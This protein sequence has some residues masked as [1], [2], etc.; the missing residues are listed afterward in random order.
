MS[1]ND[2]GEEPMPGP[3]RHRGTALYAISATC[4]AVGALLWV[5]GRTSAPPR[6]YADYL[7]ADSYTPSAWRVWSPAVPEDR[8]G[9]YLIAAGLVLAAAARL[10]SARR[11]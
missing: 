5:R 8:L 1:S 9:L 11:G 10:F 6:V 4:A 2:N 3:A 7:A